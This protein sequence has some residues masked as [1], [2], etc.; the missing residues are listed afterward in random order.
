[1][2]AYYWCLTHGQVEEGATCRAIN[3]LGPYE[4]REAALAWRDRVE[5]RNEAWQAEDERWED[6]DGD[7]AGDQRR[8]GDGGEAGD[9]R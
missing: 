6:D 3:R 4:S 2:V 7:E 9:Q 8:D 5:D 1:M